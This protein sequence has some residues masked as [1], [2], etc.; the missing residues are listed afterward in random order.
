MSEIILTNQ[1]LGRQ[2]FKAQ[3]GIELSLLKDIH[4]HTPEFAIG[5]TP[6]LLAPPSPGNENS[7]VAGLSTL[8]QLSPMY[9]SRDLANLS[10]SHQ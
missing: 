1:L 7:P 3:C 9:I 8:N 4:G 5:N 10:L 6:Y 2:A